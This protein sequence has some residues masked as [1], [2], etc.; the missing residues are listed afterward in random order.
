MNCHE[1]DCN[2]RATFEVTIAYVSKWGTRYWYKSWLCTEHT[3]AR[4][5]LV[6]TKPLT[7]SEATPA[8]LRRVS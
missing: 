4:G 1:A 6:G 2:E 3:E 5:D 8:S 7:H